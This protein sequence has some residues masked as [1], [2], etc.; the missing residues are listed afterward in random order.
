MKLVPL[1]TFGNQVNPLL[2]QRQAMGQPLGTPRII[3]GQKGQ[4]L[5]MGKSP[6]Y[7]NAMFN[8]QIFRDDRLAQN[9]IQLEGLKQRNALAANEQKFGFDKEIEGM[10]NENALA[11]NRQRFGFNKEIEGMRNDNNIKLEGLRNSNSIELQKVGQAF[12][13]EQR[14]IREAFDIQRAQ[15]REQF[16]RDEN[17][18]NFKREMDNLNKREEAAQ[19]RWENNLKKEIAMREASEKR[20]YDADAKRQKEMLTP[21]I[22]VYQK[23][24][25]D[26]NAWFMGA[27]N[28]S[29]TKEQFREDL[30]A[31]YKAKNPSENPDKLQG[32][33]AQD[34]TNKMRLLVNEA[35]MAEQKRIEAMMGAMLRNPI[36]GMETEFTIARDRL[37]ESLEEKRKLMEELKS[38][39]GNP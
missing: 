26:F 33:A 10:R 6:E 28:G 12:D 4:M 27:N 25:R 15:I 20:R 35:E 22:P 36:P 19:Q 2:A 24:L 38:L 39:E 29:K 11:Q 23:G 32:Q 17:D 34:A 18:R 1:Q 13:I 37:V 31:V 8:Q 30:I 7:L 3:Q 16:M 14:K 21:F 9:Q 5:D